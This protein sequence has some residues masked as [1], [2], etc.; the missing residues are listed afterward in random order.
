[1]S[2]IPIGSCYRE[3]LGVEGWRGGSVAGEGEDWEEGSEWEFGFL[4]NNNKKKRKT[5]KYINK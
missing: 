1:M 3:P 2:S 4:C 5:K